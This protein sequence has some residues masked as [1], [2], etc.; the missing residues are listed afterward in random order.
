MAL[1]IIPQRLIQE[2]HFGCFA[3]F[4]VKGD[5]F[6]AS[7]GESRQRDQV[8]GKTAIA[9]ARRFQSRLSNIGFFHGNSAGL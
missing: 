1:V 2:P 3:K 6:R 4:L 5:D 9:G 7:V 8:I